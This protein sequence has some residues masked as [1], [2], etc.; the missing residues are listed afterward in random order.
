MG[1]QR[2][3]HAQ[4]HALVGAARDAEVLDAVAEFAGTGHI[5]WL[6]FRDALCIGRIEPE[7]H[8]K[9]QRAENRKL[10]GG[11]DALDIKGRISF[12]IAELLGFPEHIRKFAPLVAHLGEDEIAGTVDDACQPL[13]MVAGESLANR[14]DDRDTATDC[15]L[16]GNRD[17][18][19]A[20]RCKDLL[21]MHGNECLVGRDQMLAIG[22]GLEHEFT[23][24]RIT[25]DELHDDID[26][27]VSEN[28]AGIV[29]DDDAVEP[30]E[31]CRI[32]GFCCRAVDTDIHA[33]AAADLVGIPDEHVERA[34][35]DCTESE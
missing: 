18:L 24:R 12:G 17:T 35:T 27:R 19:V 10:V 23:R 31:P 16:E 28:L 3:V 5:G 1:D 13:D 8:A 30:V 26:I 20:C 11:I 15:R 21:A 33:G 2:R 6:D 25:T 7:W 14:L 9:G 22:N 4:L 32:I 29:M 34:A